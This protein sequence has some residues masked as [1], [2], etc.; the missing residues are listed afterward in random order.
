MTGRA[1][2]LDKD[3]TLIENDTMSVDPERIRLMPG[4]GPA[5]SRFARAGFRIAIASNQPGVALG[6]FP[7]S[8]LHAV[9]ERL[10][11]LL[12]A[13]NVRLDGFHYCPHHPEAVVLEY[14]RQCDCR[15][16]APGLIHRA[17]SALGVGARHC[18]MIGDILDDVEAGHRAGCRAI[19][20]D[21]GGETEWRRSTLRTP[22]FVA[23][24]L[25]VIAD[26]VL[27]QDG[28]LA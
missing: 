24:D 26:F 3:G 17:T 5:L 2:I 25:N 1:I 20:Y 11:H 7:E 8:A 16:P 18:W 9:H 27:A 28:H 14:R 6:R 21:S 22:D 15:K 10:S 19:L 12:G 23:R 4:A 13:W